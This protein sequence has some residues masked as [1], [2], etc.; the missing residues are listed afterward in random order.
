[1]NTAIPNLMATRHDLLDKKQFLSDMIQIPD[2]LEYSAQWL[3]LATEFDEIGMIANGEYCRSRGI[4][5]GA[6][7]AGAYSKTVDGPFAEMVKA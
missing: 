4:H 2:M 6:F 3:A 5:Y 1:M 7:D